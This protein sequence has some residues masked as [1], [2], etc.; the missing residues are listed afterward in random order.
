M[1]STVAFIIAL[2]AIVFI[3]TLFIID[4]MKGSL[5]IKSK[6]V[7]DG[8][9]GYARWATQKEI[10]EAYGI[11]A[12]E[13]ERWRHGINLPS[14]IEGA[15]VLGYIEKSG[16]VYA[17]IDTSDSHTLILSTTGGFKTTGVLYPNLELTC[18]C[19]YSFLTTDTK[20]DVF[21]DYAGISQKYYGYTSYVIDL[22]NPTRSNGFNLLHLV[23]KYMDQYKIS[24]NISDKA[25]AE[26]YAKNNSKNHRTDGR[27]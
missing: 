4:T 11:I 23:N 15:T 8:Q 2:I 26:R 22:R 14:G 16:H 21:R 1:S 24:G 19:G 7:G 17:R 12:Y 6:P 27:V 10:D 20:G 13:P 18:A 9:Y 5:N 25:R 3:I